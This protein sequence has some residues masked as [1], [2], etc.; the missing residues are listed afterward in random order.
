MS[1]TD[2][3]ADMLTRI[4]NAN[5][6]QKTPVCMPSSKLKVQLA[7]LLFKEG[8][9]E[10]YEVEAASDGFGTELLVHLKFDDN[11]TPSISGLERVSKPGCRVY[12]KADKVPSVVGG[13][14][15]A[16]ISTAKCG[17]VSD[18]KARK[19]RIGGEVL[20]YVW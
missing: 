2:P 19:E 17:L 4:R 3:L 9:I 10:S 13:L 16:V 14:G 12:V 6:V 1:M 18:R 7:D 20:C 15:V 11:R 8:Y 5:S